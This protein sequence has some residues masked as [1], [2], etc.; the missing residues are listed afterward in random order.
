MIKISLIYVDPEYLLAILGKTYT[1]ISSMNGVVNKS[2]ILILSIA[3]LN[4]LA[5]HKANNSFLNPVVYS[6]FKISKVLWV[7]I[8]S[9]IKFSSLFWKIPSE[10]LL[11]DLLMQAFTY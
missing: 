10:F 8:L 1:I 9:I 4:L 7:F 5:L 2:W 3:V 11:N 6:S